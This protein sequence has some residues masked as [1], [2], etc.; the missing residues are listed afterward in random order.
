MEQTHSYLR[1]YLGMND[2]NFPQTRESEKRKYLK[3]FGVHLF[4]AEGSKTEPK[5]VENMREVIKSRYRMSASEMIIIDSN[6]GGRSTISLI[7]YV[8]KDIQVRLKKNEK[9]DH[10]W[11][12]YDK[13]SFKKDDFDNAYNKITSKNSPKYLN[14][15][16]DPCDKNNVRWHALWSNE[17]FELWVLLHFSYCDSAL[18]R[19]RYIPMINSHLSEKELDLIYEKNLTSLY[20][21]LE[22]HGN[23]S[24]AIKYARRLNQ[25]LEN[26]KIKSN[27]STG[28]YELIE[29]FYGYLKIDEIIANRV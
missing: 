24:N 2:F 18:D 22:Q 20:Q 4:Y 14:D 9:I 6:S 12:F 27:P 19:S 7:K 10:V 11:I 17:C 25:E 13:D 5:Y 23:I 15:D 21:I 1:V 8:E 3:Q 16:D 29:Y 26:P 28:I